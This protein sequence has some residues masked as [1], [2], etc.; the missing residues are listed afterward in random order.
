MPSEVTQ[1]KLLYNDDALYVGARLQRG[2]FYHSQDSEDSG[3]EAQFNPVWSGSARVDAESWTAELRIPFSQLRFNAVP[4]QTWGLQHTRNIADKSERAQWVLI[5]VSASGFAS[6]F[7]RLEGIAGIPPSRRLE[8]LPYV[9]TD[10]TFRANEN[11]ANPFNARTG[12]RAGGDL[13]LGLGSNLTLD[14][15]TN[16]DFG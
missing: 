4:E 6:Y 1:V 15:T 11:P 9:A 12:A 16:P 14:A 3:R 8:L 5:P 2:D 7:G 10:L 13:K